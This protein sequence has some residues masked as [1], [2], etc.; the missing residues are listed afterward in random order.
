MSWQ[1][2]LAD[3]ITSAAGINKRFPAADVL[4]IDTT[5]RRYPMRINPYYW[6]LIKKIGDPLWRQAVPSGLELADSVCVADPLAEE[7]LSPV[8]NLVHKYPDRVLFLVNN[9]CAMYCR[10]CTRKRKV[11]TPRMPINDDSIMAGLDYIRRTPAIKDVLVSGGD[12]FLLSDERLD[13]ILSEIRAI[14]SV[15]IIRIGT[16]TPCV[17]PMRITTK[18]TRILAHCHPL[19]INTHFNHPAEITPQAAKA[20]ER[21]ANAG[22]PLGCQTVLLRGINDDQETIKELLRSL[23]KIRVKPYYLFQG[24]L[25]RG[26]NHFRT[27]IDTGLAIM[28]SLIGHV[29]G[30]AIPTFAVDAP[31]G[32]GKIPMLPDYIISHSDE[33][34][35]DNYCGKRCSYPDVL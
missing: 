31:G 29:S 4:G 19:Y 32:G 6:A 11:G 8:T 35:F 22:I 12:P 24:D 7:S 27:S 9:Q 33:L 20:C 5:A 13:W 34:I 14:P 15:D 17:L 2:I 30:M 21:L 26:T 25:T 10:F 1:N 16:R 3:S 18:L 28:K 23:L